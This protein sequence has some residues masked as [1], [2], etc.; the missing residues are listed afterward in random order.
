MNAG[1]ISSA[2]SFAPEN[3]E[4]ILYADKFQS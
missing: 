4:R 1:T 2:A 3:V